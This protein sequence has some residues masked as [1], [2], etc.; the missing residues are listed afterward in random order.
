M[1]VIEAN[2]FEEYVMSLLE[3]PVCMEPIK[4]PPIHQCTNGHLLCKDCIAKLESCPICRNDSKTARNLIF[5]QIIGNFVAFELTNEGAYEK[6]ELQ[7]W[8][9]VSFSNNRS[10]EELSVQLNI[11][12]NS[13]T[14]E[15]VELGQS[16]NRIMSTTSKSNK[17]EE[18]VKGLLKCPNCNE[19]I[20]TTPIHQCTNGHV[21]CKNCITKLENCPNCRNDSKIARN[22]VFEQIL[23]KYSAFELEN[24]K[25]FEKAQHKE[26]GACLSS[27]GLN[28]E[29]S[30]QL[31]IQPNSETM[32]SVELGE[33]D[34]RT[35][36]T[37][38][39]DDI[40]LAFRNCLKFLWNCVKF[41]CLLLALIGLISFF[42]FFLLAFFN[43][44][45]YCMAGVDMLGYPPESCK[46]EKVTGFLS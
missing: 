22:L 1:D 19:P 32:E 24:E 17:F 30:V 7:K 43:H 34:N 15:S 14:M 18:Y 44:F 33:T 16:D 8:E 3:C 21:V 40:I 10:N 31:D 45:L 39:C 27:N 9:Q 2:K 37:L 42:I 23:E 36:S 25:P 13:K 38:I 11:Q 12:P 6:P 46:G 4:S 5:E 35:R 29:L 26:W 28:E 20:K 41:L